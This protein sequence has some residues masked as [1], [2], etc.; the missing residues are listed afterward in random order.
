R[1]TY[2][3]QLLRRRGCG[4]ASTTLCPKCKNVAN[5]M[6]IYRCRDCAGGQLLCRGC[7]IERHAENPLHMIDVSASRSYCCLSLNSFAK[8]WTG[9]YFVQESLKSIGLTVQ[10]GHPLG[11]TCPVPHAG[12]SEFVVLHDNGI[13]DVSVAFCGCVKRDEDYVQMLKAGWYPA[14]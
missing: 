3:M 1:D 9:V 2:L 11:G 14:T 8:R 4:D 7:C 13:H 12:H 5:G 6:P 10:L